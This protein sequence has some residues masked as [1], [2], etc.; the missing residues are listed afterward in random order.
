[1]SGAIKKTL[2]N[3]RTR[4]L[5]RFDQGV[6]PDD[7]FDFGEGFG[8]MTVQEFE[9]KISEMEDSAIE[10]LLSK[11]EDGKRALDTAKHIAQ[12]KID[13]FKKDKDNEGIDVN[14]GASY[15]SDT[16]CE[17]LL[18]MVGSYNKD[19]Q[20]A[21]KILR[22]EKVDGRVYT[23]KD[24][25]ELSEA[26]DLILTTVIGIQKYTAYGFRFQDGLA[27]PY[28]DKMALFP[29]FKNISTGGMANICDIMKRQGIDMLM[30]KSAV[31]VGGQEAK[32]NDW[33]AF[34]NK[35]FR[36]NTYKQKYSYIRKQFNTDPKEKD[37]MSMG[38]QMTK[39]AMS[40]LQAGRSFTVRGQRMSAED[41]RN[42][43]M[44][45]I[46]GL[47]NN[48]EK[49]LR[50]RFFN[51]DGTLDVEKFSKILT[52][53]LSRRGASTRQLDAVKTVIRG[54]DQKKQL[55]IPLAAQSGVNWIQSII[56][57]M[58]NK[59]TIDINTPG[60]AFYQRSV[61]GMQGETTVVGDE[62][63]PESINGG[64]DL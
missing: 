1:M 25:V 64:K 35:D 36:F 57:S 19:V 59:L 10:E 27:V 33:E 50:K 40:L 44:E 6:K 61:W 4:N 38:T 26:Y 55:N 52:E 18:R 34:K 42:D 30:I 47:S 13:C 21:F 48:G 2:F 45:C 51:E 63:L 41:L 29:V 49:A 15:I 12:H 62:D 37:L 39:V 3:Q 46:N 7:K 60:E 5:V 31:K 56:V 32:D 14:D 23:V 20:R 22:G 9:D 8:E 11:T 53:E 54:K 28:Y 16:M 24:T 43:I 58:I 17:T